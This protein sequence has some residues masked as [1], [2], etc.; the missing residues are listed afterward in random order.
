M[1][2]ARLI[3]TF[4]V[5]YDGKP[6]II[7]SRAAQS[8]FAYL[9]L[10]AG[11]LHRRE[12][13]AGMFWPDTSEAKARAY[14]RHEIWRIRK[15]LAPKPKDNYLLADDINI[16]FNASAE[17]WLDAAILANIGEHETADELMKALSVFRGELLPGFYEDWVVLERAHLQAVY[18]QKMGRL[19][20]L[21]DSEE[22]WNDLVQW[23]ENWITFGQG[24]EAAYRYLMIAYEALGDH[25]KVTST[26]ERCRKALRALDLEPSEQTRAL[27]FKRTSKINIPIPMTSFIGREK[28]LTEVSTLLSTC[29]LVTLTGSGG[30]GKTRLAIQVVAE[31]LELFPDGVWFVD[32]APLRDPTLVP[33]AMLTTLGLIEQAGRAPAMILTNFLQKRRALLIVDNCEH[34]IQACAQLAETLLQACAGLHILATSREAL[35]IGGERPF[36]VPSLEVPRRDSESILDELS[37]MESVILFKDRAQTALRGFVLNTKNVLEIAQICQRLDGIP[38]AIELAAACTS[39]LTV[40]HILE[41][42]DDR[43]AL[44]TG[45]LRTSLTRHQTLRATIEWS[46]QLL[47]EEE[48]LLL[49]R[50]SIFAGGWTLEAAETVCSANGIE[51]TQVLNV[52]SQLVNKSLVFVETEHDEARY[53]TL[54]TIRQFAREKLSETAESAH[55]QDRHLEYFLNLAETADPYLR[56]AEQIE[57][58]KRLDAEHENLRAALAWALARPSAEPVL[59]LAGCLWTFWFVRSYW[60]EG[61]KWLDQ[62]LGRMWNEASK[63][64]K[65]ARGRALYRRADIADALD[66]VDRMKTAAESALVLCG[67]AEDAWGIAFSRFLIA[68]CQKRSNMPQATVRSSLEQ[69]LSEFQSLGDGWGEALVMSWLAIVMLETGTR[70]E[71]FETMQQAIARARDSGDRGQIA[72]SLKALA[73]DPFEHGEWDE[74]DR[75][76]QEAEKLFVEINS[77]DTVTSQARH[78]RIQIFFAR[79]EFERAR[80]EAKRVVENRDHIGER[81]QQSLMLV[82]LALIA[83]AENDLPGAVAYAQKAL[84]LHREMAIASDI[85]FGLILVGMLEYEQGNIKVGM[86]YLRDGSEIVRGGMVDKRILLTILDYLG[87]L[88]VQRKT[89]V[90]VRVLAFTESLAQSFSVHKDPIFDKPYFDRFLSDARVKLSENEFEAAWARGSKMTLEEAVDAV[91]LG[92]Q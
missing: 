49:R 55:L 70:E 36:R 75:L 33:Q 20:K 24:P 34:V 8:L 40:P 23:A 88:I 16:S 18:E 46:Y 51:S 31:V 92:L 1:L 65:A 80:T 14:L 19:L 53:R 32:L 66:E 86:H 52:L 41:R 6:V 64:E 71:F 25:I 10:S 84:A 30:V 42:L 11:T 91:L 56:R 44:L 87:G 90:A 61:A 37:N 76:L 17:C 35:R 3:G 54:E 13:L 83:E 45:G 60:L 68:M 22:R 58:L 67:Q 29:R 81:R 74:A 78:L 57:W 62:A 27:A 9:I 73:F 48:S 15:V 38:L 12:K 21:L 4:D 47:S 82:V 63:V 2:E 5:K 89:Q 59:R 39:V 72:F 79:G 85:A 26:Y 43:F 7:S 69:S 50:L 77:S 28:E